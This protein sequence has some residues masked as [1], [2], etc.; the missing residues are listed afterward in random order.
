MVRGRFVSGPMKALGSQQNLESRMQPNPLPH[1]VPLPLREGGAGVRF[2]L[3]LLAAAC[4]DHLPAAPGLIGITPNRGPTNQPNPVA[5]TGKNLFARGDVNFEDRSQSVIDATYSAQLGSVDLQSVTLTADGTLTATVPEEMEP[6]TYDLTVVDPWNRVSTLPHAYVVF[7]NNDTA[8]EVSSFQFGHIDSQTVSTPFTITID[9]LDSTGAIAAGFNGSVILDDRTHTVVPQE[10]GSF[11]ATS[12]A[13]GEW[14]GTVEVRQVVPQDELTASLPSRPVGGPTGTSNA[15]DVTPL[16]PVALRFITPERTSPA[17]SCSPPVTVQLQDSTGLPVTAASAKQISFSSDPTAGFS[18]FSDPACGSA[19]PGSI[20]SGASAATVFFSG[21]L[22]GTVALSVSS[23]NLNGASQFET[24]APA[25]ASLLAF[26]TAPQALPAGVCS[27]IV[28]LEVQDGH[29]NPTQVSASTSISLL[30]SPASGFQFFSDSACA[31]P[32]AATTL[33]T[34]ATFGSFYFIGTAATN[35]QVTASA[36]GLMSAVQTETISPAVPSMLMFTTAPQITVAGACSAVAT[37]QSQD[38]FGNPSA[39]A[40]AT[41]VGLAAAPG[42]N[43]SFYEDSNCSIPLTATIPSG[44]AATNLYFGGTV[45]GPELVTASAAGFTSGTQQETISP[46]ATSNFTWDP[47]SSPQQVFF[48]IGVTVRARD[49]YGNP[50]PSFSGTAGLSVTPNPPATTT[51]IVGCTDA[52]TTDPFVAGVWSGSLSVDTNASASTVQLVATSGSLSG[53]SNPF[54]INLAP[55]SGPPLATFTVNPVVAQLPSCLL[56]CTP[57]VTVAFDASASTDYLTPPAT[58]QTSWDFTGNA[59]GE[60]PWTPW[61]TT[62]TTTNSYTA[63][64]TYSVRLAVEDTEPSVGYAFRRVYILPAPPLVGP[65]SPPLCVVNTNVDQDTGAS[66]CGANTVSLPDA[67]RLSNANGNVE[68][69]ITFSGPMTISS[70]GAYT[71]TAS[72]TIAAPSSVVI[73]GKT[74]DLSANV[75]LEGLTFTNQTSPIT[76]TAG[77]V[78]IVDCS[79]QSTA[80]IDM[81]GNSLTVTRVQMSQCTADCIQMNHDSP[82]TVNYSAFLNSPAY[83]GITYSVCGG[84]PQNIQSNVFANLQT[85][86]NVACGESKINIWFNTFDGNGTGVVFTNGGGK[87]LQNDIFSN[88]TV[89]A[90]DCGTAAIA[91]DNHHVLYNNTADGCVGTSANLIPTN[92]LYL[93][94][95]QNDYRLQKTSPAVDSALDLSLDTVDLAPGRYFGAGPDRGGRETW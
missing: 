26:I 33:S 73:D 94:P 65:P 91:Q 49:T 23:P 52:A 21:S 82:L 92:P 60:P 11:G 32:I 15:F 34:G 63:A 86:V 19:A 74:F 93:Y 30:A 51:C 53:T 40:T 10:V 14:V 72:V 13:A 95:A 79:F 88:Q 62:K 89:V 78:A 39:V 80:G 7:A 76:V 47:V 66:S 43:F 38:A 44:A 69:Y 37:V 36:S 41:T 8:S 31:A 54:S 35:V 5:I 24:V 61:T 4:T 3:L 42:S 58:L 16:A 50:T 18:F 70:T 27:G 48:P 59:S 71:V 6:G 55:A 20:P 77:Q 17:G 29:G 75:T 45:A 2:L 81:H 12:F 9:A 90:V 83:A 28:T 46:S 84:S 57:Q 25:S 22:A 1:H 56:L 85:G 68:Q 87:D 67:I 64:G